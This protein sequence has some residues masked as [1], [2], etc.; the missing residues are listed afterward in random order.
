MKLGDVLDVYGVKKKK[1]IDIMDEYEVIINKKNKYDTLC[2]HSIMLLSD[3][4]S[5]EEDSL[6]Y[7][8]SLYIQRVNSTNKV[9]ESGITFTKLK[10][11]MY[12]YRLDTSDKYSNDIPEETLQ[13]VIIDCFKNNK[14][15]LADGKH[16]IL[17]FD[18]M[19]EFK[20]QNSENRKGYGNQYY[21]DRRIWK[22]TEYGETTKYAFIGMNLFLLNEDDLNRIFG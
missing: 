11:E 19:V 9:L 2:I 5:D 10:T 4:V 17:L 12:H 7:G 16:H 1:S 20:A 14:H 22:G 18:N 21:Y 15:K 3:E 8:I 13:S 6:F